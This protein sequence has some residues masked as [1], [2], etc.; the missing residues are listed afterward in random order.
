MEIR[1]RK[2]YT[3]TDL[4]W[5]TKTGHYELSLAYCKALFDDNFKDDGT[6]QKRITKNSRVVWNQLMAHTYTQNKS[7]VSFILNNTEEGRNFLKDILS[8]QMESDIQFGTND[9]G[10]TP[11]INVTT[12][13]IIDRNQVTINTLCKMAE[14]VMDDVVSYVGV[15]LFIATLLPYTLFRLVRENEN[16]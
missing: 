8:A 3:D 1:I 13:H 5:N 14:D 9:L 7:V 2:P 12:G 16:L 10:I 15:N 6:L 4:V 11:L